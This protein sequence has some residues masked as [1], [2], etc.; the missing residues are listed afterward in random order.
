MGTDRL[1]RR[2]HRVRVRVRER[3]AI[4]I[5]VA[6][7]L[8]VMLGFVGL[9]ID[10]GRLYLTKT[11]LQNA[12]DACALAASYELTGAPAIAA[13]AFTRADAAGQSIGQKNK[14]DFQ[15]TAIAAGDITL[16]YSSSLAG[17][18]TAAGGAPAN[19][20]YVRCTV[21]RTG[22]QPYF[23]Q[24]LGIGD[25]TVSALATATLAPAQT[26]CAVPMALCMK[27]A[28]PNYGYAAGEWVPMDFN[29][30]GNNAN[31]TGNFRWID[32]T[33]PAG[34]ATE[35]ANLLKGSGQCSLPEPITGSCGGG[36]GQALPGCVGQTGAINSIDKAYNTR[37]GVYSP[38]GGSVASNPPDRTGN[39]YSIENWTLG[40]NAYAGAVAGQTNFKNSRAAHLP[41]T[42]PL[43]ISPKFF[44]NNDTIATQPEHTASGT[45]RRMVVLPMVDCGNFA[46][47]QYGPVRAY[48]C[49]LLLDPYRRQGNNV[50]SRLEFVGRSNVTGSPCATAGIAGNAASQGPMVPALVQ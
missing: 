27:G 31:F 2:P 34:G 42:N 10:G 18:W 1:S 46:S 5:I 22:I 4:A 17:G 35:L 44:Q 25:Q 32:F 33:P 21:R 19:S 24:V 14:V 11:E 36:G 43:G 16:T 50:T 29:E 9:A 26:N 20:K 6:L 7:T 47:G 8:S 3:G 23:M 48:A 38:G 45:D 30:Q 41:I 28:A 40:S 39:S 37:F 49:V 12:A 13:D 15:G